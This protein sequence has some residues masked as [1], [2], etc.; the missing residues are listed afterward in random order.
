MLGSFP[1]LPTYTFQESKLSYNKE[2]SKV[3][4]S[5]TVVPTL[6]KNVQNMQ[7]CTSY[8]FARFISY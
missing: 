6:I 1:F 7:G 2:S 8:N 4:D 5:D 3:D